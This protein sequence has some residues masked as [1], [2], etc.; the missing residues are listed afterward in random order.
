MHDKRRI[1]L[2]R[3][4]AMVK[5]GFNCRVGSDRAADWTVFFCSAQ[6]GSA[7]KGGAPGGW[8]VAFHWSVF[9]CSPWRLI[10]P[11]TIYR[12]MHQQVPYGSIE[13]LHLPCI[14]GCLNVAYVSLTN[15]PRYSA[16]P[17][18]GALSAQ[19]PTLKPAKMRTIQFYFSP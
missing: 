7:V 17:V 5:N 4:S 19:V 3:P 15:G 1:S 16:F 18:S 6:V 11:H 14:L 10:H 2:I 8:R 9:F 12:T 13:I